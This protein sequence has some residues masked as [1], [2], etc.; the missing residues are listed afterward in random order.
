MGKKGHVAE[1]VID[2]A[3]TARIDEI[4]MNLS[5]GCVDAVSGL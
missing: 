3:A 4:A 5:S 2:Q 1:W